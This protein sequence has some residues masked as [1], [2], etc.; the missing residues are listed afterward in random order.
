MTLMADLSG[1]ASAG[2]PA[3]PAFTPSDLIAQVRAAR[4]EADAAEVRILEL[5]L[6]WAVANPAL[7]DDD[8]VESDEDDEWA[9]I[10]AVRWDA[11]AA[12]AAANRMTTAAGTALIRDVLVLDHRLPATW[13]RTRAGHVPAWRA[14]RIAER[15][16]GEPDDVAAYVDQHVARRAGTVGLVTLDR[17]IDEAKLRLHAEEREIEQLE[18]L[19]AR[20]ARLDEMSI[21]YTGI[22]EM[23]LRG[24]WPDLKAFD[25]A[26]SRVAAAL[27]TAD[28]TLESE[29]LDVRRSLAVGV[30]ADPERAQAL[31]TDAPKPPPGRHALLHVHLTEG[32]LLGVDPV[33]LDADGRAVL[34]Q[35]IRQWCGRD[36]AKV[37]VRPV[38]DMTGPAL[39]GAAHEH[40]GH[41]IDDYRPSAEDR[42]QVALRDRWCV[43]PYCTRRAD[44]CDCDHI[45]PHAR[46]GP[47]CPCNLAPSCRHHHRLKTHAGW[48]YTMIEPGVY[49]WADR[50][51]Q[52]FLRTPDGTRDIT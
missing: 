40:T 46:G 25:E 2:E 38:L 12:F 44:H 36:D 24:D 26:L 19:D 39:T 15:V 33:A 4:A 5:A 35:V 43:F 21:N 29:S 17:L 49:L 9:G 22:V 42:E 45:V 6:A 47:T 48:R 3:M 34:D 37:I 28:P 51:G 20:Y 13:R 16:L 18:A 41:A 23:H 50:Y 30:L 27:V 32:N 31:L 10:P 1:P 7:P 11:P 14:R 52:Q 8:D